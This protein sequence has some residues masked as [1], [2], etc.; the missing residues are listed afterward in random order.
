MKRSLGPGGRFVPA[1]RIHAKRPRGD[2]V[3]AA[4]VVNAGPRRVVAA[5]RFHA[6]TA[7]AFCMQRKMPFGSAIPIAAIASARTWVSA[8]E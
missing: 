3:V 7:T 6:S 5:R 8:T 4:P 1:A 2:E